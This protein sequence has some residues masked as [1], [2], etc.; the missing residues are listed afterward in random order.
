MNIPTQLTVAR[1]LLAL[2]GILLLANARSSF[3]IL[4][5]TTLYII[6]TATDV[7][8]GFLARRMG[9][10]T[11]SGALMD[12]T[13]DNTLFLLY[14]FYLQYFGVYPPW[15]FAIM[16][17]GHIARLG[18][19]SFAIQ[20]QKTFKAFLSASNIGT[21]AGLLPLKRLMQCTP[22]SGNLSSTNYT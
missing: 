6:A 12:S 19:L 9:C 17:T 11:K 14:F 16:L 2:V 5:S 7:L 8:D 15:L 22:H 18:A 20:D 10:T 21:P 3:H 13:A 1:F 4:A